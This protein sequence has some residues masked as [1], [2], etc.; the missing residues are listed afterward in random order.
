MEPQEPQFG[1]WIMLAGVA[2]TLLGAMLTLLTKMG[3]FRLPGDLQF[4]SKNFRIYLPL[5]SCILISAILTL[6]LWLISILRR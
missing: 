1:K 4:G 5:A 3:L 6:V 2:L